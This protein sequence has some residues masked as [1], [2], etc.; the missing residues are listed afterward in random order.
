M[1]ET[2]CSSASGV[3]RDAAGVTTPAAIVFP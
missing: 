2:M 3:K 1:K